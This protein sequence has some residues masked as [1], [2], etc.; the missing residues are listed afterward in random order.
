MSCRSSEI[1]NVLPTADY[2]AT[3]EGEGMCES[4]CVCVSLYACT[5]ASISPPGCLAVSLFS[6][7]FFLS[8]AL[9]MPPFCAFSSPLDL[10]PSV[11]PSVCQFVCLFWLGLWHMLSMWSPCISHGAIKCVCVCLPLF[12]PISPTISLSLFP[13][14]CVYICAVSQC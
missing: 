14:C 6:L 9:F 13:P 11:R 8:F 2:M 7:L 10:R 12:S 1:K 3:G 4:V 5:S